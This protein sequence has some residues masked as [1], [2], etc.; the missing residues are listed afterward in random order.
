MTSFEIGVVIFMVTIIFA[1]TRIIN[2][3]DEIKRQ[4]RK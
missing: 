3:L 4:G 1:L 2:L